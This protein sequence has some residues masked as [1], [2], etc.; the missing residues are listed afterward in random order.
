[1]A[2]WTGKRTGVTFNKPAEPSFLKEFK[3]KAGYKEDT[4]LEDKFA[5]QPLA[6]AEDLADGEEDL[7]QVV[8]CGRSL[9]AAE[10]AQLQEDGRLQQ[11]LASGSAP[12]S[13][14]QDE[15]AT[16]VF[17][18]PSKKRGANDGP[19]SVE[20]K[21]SHDE[22]LKKKKRKKMEAEKQKKL[23]SFDED[24]DSE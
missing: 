3:K 24:Q 22:K 20:D 17:R 1:M 19:A 12:A 6:T 18:Q 15:S 4:R 2:K 8:S 10:C 5:E 23:L 13:T 11:L 9:S 21:A 14:E 16:P 7:P